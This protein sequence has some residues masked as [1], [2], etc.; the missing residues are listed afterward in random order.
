MRDEDV[1]TTNLSFEHM[2]SFLLGKKRFHGASGHLSPGAWRR[3]IVQIF[4]A[5]DRAVRETVR[6]DERH[7]RQIERRCKDAIADLGKARSTGRISVAA[8]EHLTHVAFLIIGEWPNN[9]EKSPSAAPRSKNWSL[10]H[11]LTLQY[12]RS[13]EQRVRQIIA[14]ADGHEFKGRLPSRHE[15][16]DQLHRTCAGD[17][18]RFIAWFKREYKDIYIELE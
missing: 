4:K 14:L 16:Y 3:Q 2:M 11:Y 1:I 15:L 7:M 12:L 9:W 13:H 6:G 10:S 8:I 5:L 18:R 17:S